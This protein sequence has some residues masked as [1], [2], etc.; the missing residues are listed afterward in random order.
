MH[1]IC[2]RL[3]ICRYHCIDGDWESFR[4]VQDVMSKPS[5]I[6]WLEI[7]TCYLLQYQPRGLTEGCFTC[8]YV[9]ISCLE[10]PN[11][12]KW[13]TIKTVPNNLSPIW[14]SSSWSFYFSLKNWQLQPALPASHSLISWLANPASSFADLGQKPRQHFSL[15]A[16]GS[17]T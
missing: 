10:P 3:V 7:T 8:C 2:I 4:S 6:H 16:Y 1:L 15:H 12:K 9:S 11:M 5:N 14:N 13:L 17:S